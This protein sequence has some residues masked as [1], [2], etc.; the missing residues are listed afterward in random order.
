MERRKRDRQGRIE[1]DRG[2]GDANM[3]GEREP[4]REG[5]K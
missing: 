3:V 1:I 4:A 5:R 2:E